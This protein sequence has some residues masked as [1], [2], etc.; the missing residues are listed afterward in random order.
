MDDSESLPDEGESFSPYQLWV[1]SEHETEMYS[2]LSRLVTS[3][4]AMIAFQLVVKEQTARGC[5]FFSQASGKRSR[6]SASHLA[7]IG[8]PFLDIVDALQEMLWLLLSLA[9][10]CL[11]LVCLPK[12]SH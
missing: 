2:P 4:E 9:V 5:P 3:L 10:L 12:P 6:A 11:I 8:T 7:H 1:D